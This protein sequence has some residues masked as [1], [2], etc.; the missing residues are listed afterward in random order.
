MATFLVILKPYLC[1]NL[2]ETGFKKIVFKNTVYGSLIL[3]V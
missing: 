2:A 1:Y 3:P